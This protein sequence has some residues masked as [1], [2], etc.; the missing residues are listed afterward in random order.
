MT[1]DVQG[2]LS[3]EGVTPSIASRERGIKKLHR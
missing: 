2:N 1:A 3:M